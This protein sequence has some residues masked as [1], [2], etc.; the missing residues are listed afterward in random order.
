MDGLEVKIEKAKEYETSKVAKLQQLHQY[1]EEH[2]FRFGKTKRI[3]QRD[4]K[5]TPTR[6][7]WLRGKFRQ[8]QKL[9]QGKAKQEAET[10]E[11]NKERNSQVQNV[12]LG[13]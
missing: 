11:S 7:W 3:K 5:G 6:S 2:K 12:R 8:K 13:D 10:R 4:E 9:G 1:R